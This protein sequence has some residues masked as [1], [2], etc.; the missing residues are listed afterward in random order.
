MSPAEAMKV[1]T[2]ANVHRFNRGL[3]GST[4]SFRREEDDLDAR[5]F[6]AGEE[7]SRGGGGRTEETVG[8]LE[9]F[10]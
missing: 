10:V 7:G 2:F 1:P 8:S 5:C 4:F 3:I 9:V 6:E